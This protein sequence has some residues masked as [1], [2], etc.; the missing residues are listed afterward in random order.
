MKMKIHVITS[1]V[2]LP[3]LNWSTSRP[4]AT[5]VCAIQPVVDPHHPSSCCCRKRRS[6]NSTKFYSLSFLHTAEHRLLA[7][8]LLCFLHNNCWH[9][10]IPPAVP[11]HR[12]T[13]PDAN[14]LYSTNRNPGESTKLAYEDPVLWTYPFP[15]P[16]VPTILP[17]RMSPLLVVVLCI[18]KQC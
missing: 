1:E 13:V 6:R 17:H 7:S 4:I 15:L 5:V 18:E 16:P 10:T 14:G 9:T 12:T 8:I 11:A 2:N 3:I